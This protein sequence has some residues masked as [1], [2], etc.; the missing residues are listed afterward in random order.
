MTAHAPP[1]FNAA[2]RRALIVSLAAGVLYVLAD[3]TV[4]G[5]TYF[6]LLY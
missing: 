6:P 3:A 1:L 5:G 4:K 2:T